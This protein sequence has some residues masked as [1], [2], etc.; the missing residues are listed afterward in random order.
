MPVHQRQQSSIF[1]PQ[2]V[3]GLP[4][5]EEMMIDEANDVETISHDFGIGEIFASQ[6]AVGL[7]EI[8][9]NDTDFAFIGELLEIRSKGLFGAAESYVVD[10]VMGQV[11]EGGGITLFTGKEMFIDAK[12][13]RAGFSL[14]S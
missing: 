4:E 8:H 3:D 6:V 11:A 2:R 9:D 12:D 14:A 10:F 13:A 5:F 7:R 1:S